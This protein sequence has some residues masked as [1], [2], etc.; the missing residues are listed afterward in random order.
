[1]WIDLPRLHEPFA[2][3]FRKRRFRWFAQAFGLGPKT[4]VLDL[5]GYEYY[6]S[7]FKQQPHVTIVN[8]DRDIPRS[9]GFRWVIA[10]ARRLP[11]REHS[12]DIVF[13]NSV[14]EHL[15]DQQSRS[16]FARESARVGKSYYIQTPNYWFPIEPHLMT[17]FIHYFP[18]KL[19]KR[20]LRNFTL[21]G[22]LVRPT[23]QGCD[24]F[25]DDVRLLN[26]NELRAL[27]P[28][29]RIQR[30]RFLGLTKSLIA[31]FQK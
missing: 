29:A 20:L 31:I 18:K 27:F 9:T 8:L 1:M 17:P 24:E 12:F 30:E 7:Y 4:Q 14:V 16:Q 26:V 25:V 5:G 10:D 23:R 15:G 2:R 6:W 11:F 22:L 28:E 21:W 3:Y 13:A 19:R